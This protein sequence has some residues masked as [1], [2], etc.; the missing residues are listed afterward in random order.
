[1]AGRKYVAFIYATIF[2]SVLSLIAICVS[3]GTEG[4]IQATASTVKVTDSVQDSKVYQGLFGGT[5][6]RRLLQTPRT[7]ELYVTCVW[8]S[9]ACAWSCLAD[10]AARRAEVEALLAG[11]SPPFACLAAATTTTSADAAPSTF[12]ENATNETSV[13][14]QFVNAGAWLSTI[15]ILALLTIAVILTI[16]LSIL[17][18]FK[19][20]AEPLL[21]IEG[22]YAMTGFV[23][24]LDVVALLVYGCH[25]LFVSRYNVAIRDT[26][27]GEYVSESTLGY[28]YW[29]LSIPLCLHVANAGLF[30]L[31][32]R[33]VNGVPAERNVDVDGITDGRTVLF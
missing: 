3:M 4:W 25:Y 27:V 18:S 17:N 5:L 9:N 19:S 20:P 16:A 29:S 21:N 6:V 24:G 12:R 2:L 28:S 8:K 1:M 14:P 30:G 23:I 32:E 33:L 10:G 13:V 22:I 15:L 11:E 31:R 7:Y 26:I